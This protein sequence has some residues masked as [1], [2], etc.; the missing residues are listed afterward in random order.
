MLVTHLSKNINTGISVLQEM[1]KIHTPLSAQKLLDSSNNCCIFMK[2][3]SLFLGKRNNKSESETH[4][5]CLNPLSQ[6]NF[7]PK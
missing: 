4:I 6:A 5:T 1:K 7:M 2:Q 3:Y